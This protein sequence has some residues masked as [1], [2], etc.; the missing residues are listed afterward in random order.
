M[1]LQPSAERLLR[2]TRSATRTET[3]HADIFIQIWPVD[4]LAARDQTPVG[5]L[6]GRPMRQTRE[7]GE[8]HCNGSAIRRVRDQSIIAYALGKRLSELTP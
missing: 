7:P 2:L 1:P 4:P 3:L 6:L 5:A 8:W